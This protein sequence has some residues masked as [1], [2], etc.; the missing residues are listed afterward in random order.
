ALARAI[1]NLMDNAVR[2]AT[3]RVAVTLAEDESGV[4]LTV[5]DNG[6]GVPRTERERIFERFT[7]LDDARSR[8]D[9]GTGLGLAI[10][11]DV[12]AAP[13]GTTRLVGGPGA[14][15]VACF[16]LA[17]RATEDAAARSA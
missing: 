17:D 9:G 10:T 3:S 5:S 12:V 14:R 11:H 8:D 13:A 2:H 16:P 1:R 15:F 4:A 6:P 7:R